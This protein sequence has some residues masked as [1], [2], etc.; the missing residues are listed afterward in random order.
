MRVRPNIAAARTRLG[1]PLSTLTA[2]CT[3]T[4]RAQGA[5]TLDPTTGAI[6]DATSTVY[7]GPCS[8]VADT[9]GPASSAGDEQR[10]LNIFVLR[11][12][13]TAT[14]ILPGDLVSIGTAPDPDLTAAPLKVVEV[15]ARTSNVLRTVRCVDLRRVRPGP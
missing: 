11:V 10:D 12:P 2:A 1:G 3:I 7:T 14:G 8:V 15:E 9:A 6:S 13:L 5:G 4:R